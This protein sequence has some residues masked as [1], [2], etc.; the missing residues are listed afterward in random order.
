M[1]LYYYRARYYHPTLS[2]FISED[3]LGIAAGPN[4]YAYVGG[5]PVNYFDPYGLDKTTWIPLGPGRSI[6]D[7]PR[8]GNWGG[9]KWSGGVSGGG[10]GNAPPLDSGDACYMRHDQ[11]YDSGASMKSCDA[12][13]INELK[14]LPADPKAWPTPP[15][16]GTEGD[17]DQFRRGAIIIFGK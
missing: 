17:S 2:R 15:A 3:P 6:T 7:G 12:K 13:L 14:S 5:N 10:T 11:C 4:S 9:G 8:N 16:R 1:V